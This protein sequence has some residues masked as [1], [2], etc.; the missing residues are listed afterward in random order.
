MGI[1]IEGDLNRFSKYLDKLNNIDKE[2]LNE[3]LAEQVRTSTVLRFKQEKDPEGKSWKKSRRANEEGGQTLSK[4][5]RLKN[6]LSGKATNEGFAV[7]TNVIYAATHQF[8]DSDRTILPKKK[9]LLRFMVNGKYVTAKKVVV[10]IP[11][12]P[13]LGMSESDMLELQDTV[14]D[15]LKE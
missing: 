15:F 1:K 8:G 4:T 13:F 6:S 11:A 9:K 7:G 14:D 5:A 12:R 3:V 2:A 10:S